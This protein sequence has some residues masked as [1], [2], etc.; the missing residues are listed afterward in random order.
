MSHQ[1]WSRNSKHRN[2]GH[3]LHYVVLPAILMGSDIMILFIGHY[4]GST[5]NIFTL[6]AFNE[7]I[8]TVSLIDVLPGIGIALV[9]MVFVEIIVR[10]K[11][12]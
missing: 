3:I 5:Q 6:E 12:I 11:N 8:A 10:L 2:I 4:S 1:I 7:Y 9:V